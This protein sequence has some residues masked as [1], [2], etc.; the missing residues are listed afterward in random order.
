M[1]RSEH[2]QEQETN[3]SISRY[4]VRSSTLHI[5]S[6]NVNANA[7]VSALAVAMEVATMTRTLSSSS[8]SSDYITSSSWL[9]LLRR[10]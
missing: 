2:E 7:N 3:E 4:L 5:S 10:R 9:D 8:S 1:T 6:V